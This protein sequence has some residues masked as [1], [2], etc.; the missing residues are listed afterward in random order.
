MTRIAAGAPSR[1]SVHALGLGDGGRNGEVVESPAA[2]A[3]DAGVEG[4]RTT[5]GVVAEMTR[6]GATGVGVRGLT[7]AV[8]APVALAGETI[9]RKR[10]LARGVLKDGAW[11]A[12][13][14]SHGAAAEALTGVAG[15]RGSDL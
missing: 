13:P 4:T 6:N 11:G 12:R 5:S 7:T 1:K 10:S 3:M 15:T 14:P 2:E 8:R 9:S